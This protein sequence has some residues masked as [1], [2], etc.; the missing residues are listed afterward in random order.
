[1][2]LQQEV[3]KQKVM[4][5][6]VDEMIDILRE[7]LRMSVA[8]PQY[9]EHILNSITHDLNYYGD[10]NFVHLLDIDFQ[11]FDYGVG[12]TG[13]T[14]IYALETALPLEIAAFSKEKRALTRMSRLS[15]SKTIQKLRT[16]VGLWESAIKQK[17]SSVPDIETFNP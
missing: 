5:K 6:P 17:Y 7:G 10:P 16:R 3:F 11:P 2:W 15:N 4:S 9:Q 1:M 13:T 8:T 14:G 12:A